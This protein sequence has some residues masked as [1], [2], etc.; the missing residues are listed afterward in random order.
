MGGFRR[1]PDSKRSRI[2]SWRS[3]AYTCRM[4]ADFP[5]YPTITRTT[6]GMVLSILLGR[7]R[8]FLADAESLVAAVKPPLQVIGQ[9]PVLGREPAVELSIVNSADI[10][11]DPYH[12]PNAVECEVKEHIPI[13][14]HTFL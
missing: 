8:S 3:R 7:K 11:T 2:A 6:L 10:D 14:N 9:V 13:S 1:R 12:A 5:R 4:S